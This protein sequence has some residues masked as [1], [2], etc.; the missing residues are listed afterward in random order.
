MSVPP[1]ALRFP[2][3]RVLL[4]RTRLAYIHLKNLLTD[5]KRD[6]AARISGYVAVSLID[7]LITLYLIRG[8]VANATVRAPRG[9][10]AIAI[11][12][13]LDKIPAEPEY[14]EVCF[15]EAMEEQLSCMF[16]TQ[17]KPPEPWPEGMAMHDPAVLFP[18][19]MSIT[20]DGV[21]EIIAK[22]HVNYLI[23]TNGTVAR[24]FLSSAHHGTVVDRVAKLFSRDGRITDLKVSR[25]AM[26][27]RL[28]VQA[29]PALV[30]AYRELSGSLVDRLVQL[31]R[32]TAPQLAEQARASLIG[33]HPALK[34]FSF[35]GTPSE[36]PLTDAPGL[37]AGMAA[38]MR[39]VLW[40]ASEQDSVA[41][42]A[43]LREL[44]WD[45]RHMFQS[46]G[47]FEQM[48]WKVL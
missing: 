9:S 10:Q 35:V 28:P 1:P 37:T 29:S 6:R 21:L 26:P 48:P 13:A 11:S 39:D 24:A 47:L 41:P 42:D 44:T 4:P 20:F 30:Q 45:R 8:E 22:E 2:T 43:L 19:L 3:S 16:D 33:A 12:A 23:F 15:N 31:G 36:D 18:Y 34:G 7:E 46:A 32:D 14:G 25:W 40:A 27:S 38:W 5:A 17:S